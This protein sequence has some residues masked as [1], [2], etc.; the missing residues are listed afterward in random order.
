MTTPPN[1]G[2]DLVYALLTDDAA[3]AD[4]IYADL[5]GDRADRLA[6]IAGAIF[7]EMQGAY[8]EANPDAQSAADGH[9]LAIEVEEWLHG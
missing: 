6:A 7:S 1:T 3:A 4:A 9:V 2:R 8:L 5:P